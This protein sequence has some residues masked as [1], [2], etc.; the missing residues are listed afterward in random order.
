MKNMWKKVI[1]ATAGI[2]GGY[3]VVR[4]YLKKFPC[5]WCGSTSIFQTRSGVGIYEGKVKP[6]LDRTIAVGALLFFSP[7][8]ALISIMIVMDDPG[9]VFFVQKRVGKDKAY[10]M[11]HKF[12]SMKMDAPHDIPTHAFTEPDQYI[13]R[14]GKFLRKASLDE[15]PQ[16]WDIIRGRMSFIGPRPALWNQKDLIAQRD[17]YGANSIMPGLSGWAQINGRDRLEIA[18]KARLDGEYASIL[19]QGGVQAFLFDCKCFLHTVISVAKSDGVAEGGVREIH[20]C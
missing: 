18:D 7:L 12:R 20:R 16:V 4:A 13:T 2:V 9:P 1:M 6:A 5:D 10:F 8:F 19:R 15:L 14:V 11:C 3:Q 17:R